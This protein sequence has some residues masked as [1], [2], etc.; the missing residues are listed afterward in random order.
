MLFSKRL[1]PTPS[2][3]IHLEITIHSQKPQF[4]W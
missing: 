4:P 2:L 3:A 1:T